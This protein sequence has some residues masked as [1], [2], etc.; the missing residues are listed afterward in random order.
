MFEQRELTYGLGVGVQGWGL[1]YGLGVGEPRELTYG[2][3]VGEQRELIYELG[4][5]CRGSSYMC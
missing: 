1:T 3:R 2:L 4:V 5:W